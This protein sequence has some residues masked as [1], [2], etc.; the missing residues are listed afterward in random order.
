MLLD[1]AKKEIAKEERIVC[2]N[3]DWIALVPYWA[4]WPYETM[5]LPKERHISRMSDLSDSDRQSLADI[6]IQITTRYDN[7][8]ETSF[9]YSMGFHGAPTGPNAAG[10]D[11]WQFHALYFPPLLRSATV[12]KF[13]VGFEM[14]GRPQRDFTPEY[15]AEVLKSL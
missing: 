12:K 2:S 4:T 3:A 14:Q 11:H 9:P 7:L 1:Y 13:M 10:D 15:A 6:M 8:F 5:I